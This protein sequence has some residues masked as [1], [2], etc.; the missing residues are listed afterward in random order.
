MVFRGQSHHISI[1]CKYPKL[2]GVSQ[3]AMLVNVTFSLVC[4]FL[5]WPW[6]FGFVT[7]LGFFTISNL[8]LLFLEF[9][10][11]FAVLG[12]F[13]FFVIWNIVFVII[14]VV[15]WSF[16]VWMDVSFWWFGRRK[17]VLIFFWEGLI[18]F[19]LATNVFVSVSFSPVFCLRT[20]QVLV[21]WYVYNKH[22]QISSGT[23]LKMCFLRSKFFLSFN[24]G[25]PS[26][27]GSSV[28]FC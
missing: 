22:F 21:F 6:F 12:F 26:W 15:V 19:I 3:I 25:F 9:F 4:Y 28:S 1:D 17:K 10:K 27:W 11:L 2:Y 5:R 13:N 20:L 23:L 7:F 24:P 14:K 16:K 18:C 8:F